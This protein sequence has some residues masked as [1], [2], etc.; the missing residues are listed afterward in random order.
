L[1]QAIGGVAPGAVPFLRAGVAP[2]RVAGVA[3]ATPAPVAPAPAPRQRPTGG[4]HLSVPLLLAAVLVG[5]FAALTGSPA[6]REPTGRWLDF[7]AAF[8]PAWFAIYGAYFASQIAAARRDE[9]RLGA[10]SARALRGDLDGAIAAVAP[11]VHGRR[12]GAQASAHLLL[13][14]IAERRGLLDDALA[15][16][17]HGLAA[18]HSA[19]LRAATSE[20]TYPALVGQRA[21]VLAALGREDDAAVELAALP[22]TYLLAD[23]VRRRVELVG[24]VRRGAFDEARR[25]VDAAPPD[26]GGSRRD[27]LLMDLVRAA[28][29]GAGAAEN[30]RLD[31]ELRA[32]PEGRRWLEAVAP[33]ALAAFTRLRAPEAPA[34]EEAEIEALAALEAEA[35]ARARVPASAR[36]SSR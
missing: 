24:L 26:L 31:E 25:L 2:V 4:V 22:A 21:F 16:C 5:L 18:L 7:A 36:R 23:A 29:G 33:P 1:N 35:P 27:E 12:L 13:A 34:D 32:H 15:S 3:S 6:D 14:Q 8:L 10:A 20:T 28:A 30:E 17:D 11:L 9:R 19:A